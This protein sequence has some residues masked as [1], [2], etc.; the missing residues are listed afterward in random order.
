M[1][2]VQ[3]L[4]ILLIVGGAIVAWFI[5]IPRRPT[6]T[7]WAKALAIL[8][9]IGLVV[10]DQVIWAMTR[11]SI[12]D[13]ATC[14]AMPTAPSCVEL[15]GSVVKV[16]PQPVAATKLPASKPAPS[17]AAVLTSP[18]T[19]LVLLVR[20][21]D[22]DGAALYAFVVVRG[23]RFRDFMAAQRRGLFYPDRYGEVV[24]S[25]SG[26]PTDEVYAEMR[27][28]YNFDRGNMIDVP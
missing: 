19:R 28:L 26:E 3:L 6:L 5:A 22:P 9:P 27:E 16:D 10:S 17:P 14:A 24:R 2:K 4:N 8:V 25:G 12:L 15:A 1:L 20:G 11:K 21:K 7:K 23:D 18:E 13:H